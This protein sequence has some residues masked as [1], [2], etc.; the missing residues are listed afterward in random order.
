MP[1][2]GGN[3][4]APATRRRAPARPSR[5]V[6]ASAPG[7]AGCRRRRWRRWQRDR[8]CRPSLRARLRPGS[9]PVG[10]A[11]V[12]HLADPGEP[13]SGDDDVP[14]AVPDPEPG[15]VGRHVPRQP[16]PEEVEVV[17]CLP[18]AA[19]G[20]AQVD[21]L[22]RRR[23]DRPGRHGKQRQ[24]QQQGAQQSGHGPNSP[25]ALPVVVPAEPRSLA[26]GTGAGAGSGVNSTAPLDAAGSGAGSGSGAGAL[27]ARGRPRLGRDPAPEQAR[28]RFVVG[29]ALAPGAGKGG[30]DP[31]LEGRGLGLLALDRQ[32]RR[33]DAA[34]DAGRGTAGGADADRQHLRQ[35]RHP[36]AARCRRSGDLRERRVGRAAA[37]A[38]GELRPARRARARAGSG[39]TGSAGARAAAAPGA[40]R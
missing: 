10:G 4:A 15:G 18:V 26:A 14:A 8:G 35:R 36:G 13:E 33:D 19:R 39:E 7:R 22:Q 9:A 31:P 38:R 17:V 34:R 23:R 1:E 12:L 29:A 28:F 21:R 3:G 6:P 27:S 32:R 20:H 40:A 24:R 30:V 5:R 2:T 16:V 11:D 37:E 25:A